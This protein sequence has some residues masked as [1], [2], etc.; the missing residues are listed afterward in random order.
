MTF[1]LINCINSTTL[2]IINETQHYSQYFLVEPHSDQEY[3]VA[4]PGFVEVLC[5]T[6]LLILAEA[7]AFLRSLEGSEEPSVGLQL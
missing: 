4:K 2:C 6:R 1:V 3:I 5:E 7:E